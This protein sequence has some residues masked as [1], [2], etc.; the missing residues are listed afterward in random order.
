MTKNVLVPVA[1]GIEELEAV[2]II[3]VLRRAGVLVRVCSVDDR[4]IVCANGVKLIADS[5]FSDERIDQYDALVLP[6]GTE[7]AKRFAAHCEL[8]QAIKQFVADNHL[9]AAICASP[10]LVLASLGVLDNKKA[11]GYPSFKQHIKN[12]VNEPVVIDGAIIT[13]QG[14]GTALRFALTVAEAL[15]GKEAAEQ[16]RNGM[17][18]SQ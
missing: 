15:A 18:A 10:G 12:Y 11:T 6:G 13:S 2:T 14:P 9:V 4:E 5:Q 17:L 3:D 1:H 16:V 7:G 8:G